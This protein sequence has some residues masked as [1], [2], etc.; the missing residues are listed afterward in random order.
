MNTTR[1]A[2]TLASSP[3]FQFAKLSTV[4]KNSEEHVQLGFDSF[5]KNHIGLYGPLFLHV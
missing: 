5:L 3:F 4:N 2:Q 1:L